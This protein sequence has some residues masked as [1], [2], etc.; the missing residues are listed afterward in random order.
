MGLFGS[1]FGSF[2]GD[3]FG[4]DGTPI[5]TPT[6]TGDAPIVARLLSRLVTRFQT[7][8][9]IAYLRALAQ[10]AAD[11]A[12]AFLQLI[13][14]TS[15]DD[16]TGI[17]LDV[18]GK[19]VGQARLGLVDVDYRRYLR[20]R[21]AA[22]RSS[23]ATDTIYRVAR[24]VIN[25]P[26]V[27]LQLVTEG[28]AAFSLFVAGQPVTG[29]TQTALAALVRAAASAG[30][31]TWLQTTTATDDQILTT[32]IECFTTTA[33][34]IGA[35]VLVVDDTSAFPI[36]GSVIVDQGN[37]ATG[38]EETVAYSGKLAT[39]LLLTAPLG[40]NHTIRSQV[41]LATSPGRGVSP[42]AHLTPGS[43]GAGAGSLTVDDTTGFPT[44][45]RI[46]IDGGT[47]LVETPSYSAKT[48]TTF[49]LV[50]TTGFTHL[51][52]ALITNPDQGGVLDDVIVA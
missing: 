46:E 25:D 39:E 34:S 47:S 5:P 37:S 44:S 32:P 35:M 12:A 19:I 31:R 10:P 40:F 20:A 50:G 21:I 49:T 51:Q 18:I 7:P 9:R 38:N 3:F 22:N 13:T 17:Q 41:V 29:A 11:I 36:S 26:T 16:C 43:T 28:V 24:L 14:I 45:G 42:T 48:G 6:D 2:F 52:N 27:T 30:V 15:I 8:N 1:Y 33:P 4:D 23:G